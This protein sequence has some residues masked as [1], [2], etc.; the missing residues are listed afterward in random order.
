M[1]E[2]LSSK[3]D[4]LVQAV[5][6]LSP[7]KPTQ[8][9]VVAVEVKKAPVAETKKEDAPKKEHA[10]GFLKKEIAAAVSPK[11]VLKKKVVAKK[12]K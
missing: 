5:E 11:K 9:K 1:I 7:K 10:K 6:A 4:K 8:E 12:G 3:I 2:A